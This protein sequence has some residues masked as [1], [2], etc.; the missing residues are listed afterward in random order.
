MDCKDMTLSFEVAI[1]TSKVA[2]DK[3]GNNLK[4]QFATSSWGGVR[5]LPYAFTRNGIG[6]LS[7]VL[8]SETAVE[9]NIRIMRAITKMQVTPE[10]ILGL[11]K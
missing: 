1:A 2:E 5:K 8:R 6:M 3:S 11:L 4:S 9:V 10:T 7:S